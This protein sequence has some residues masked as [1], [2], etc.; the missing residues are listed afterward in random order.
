MRQR[1]RCH[2][3]STPCSS[4]QRWFLKKLETAGARTR[5]GAS[6][7]YVWKDEP[8]NEDVAGGG[9][10]REEEERNESRKKSWEMRRGAKGQRPPTPFAYSLFWPAQCGL[11]FSTANRFT[12]SSKHCCLS[13]KNPSKKTKGKPKWSVWAPA[14]LVLVLPSHRWPRPLQ[15]RPS[16]RDAGLISTDAKDLKVSSGISHQGWAQRPWRRR[17][18]ER[19]EV[20]ERGAQDGI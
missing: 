7:L 4:A 18:R 14:A 8:Q 15:T 16:D 2:S 6:L 10:V 13:K 1:A 5:K 20:G 3:G 9:R 19:A 12:E 17:S 11:M